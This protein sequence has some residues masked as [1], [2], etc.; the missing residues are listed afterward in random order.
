MIAL[1]QQPGEL[2][3]VRNPIVYRF[4]STD[5]VGEPYQATGFV[6]RILF[7]PF[8][9]LNTG[10][11]L[12]LNWSDGES[13]YSYTFTGHPAPTSENQLL[14]KPHLLDAQ[15]YAQNWATAFESHPV[16]SAFFTITYYTFG[17]SAGIILEDKSKNPDFTLSFDFSDASEF[18]AGNFL[19]SAYV[20]TTLPDNYKVKID[21]YFQSEFVDGTYHHVTRLEETPDAD[22]YSEIDLED[23]LQA[24]LIN[25]FQNPDLPVINSSNLYIANNLRRYYIRF[26]EFYGTPVQEQ[27]W[28]FGSTKKVINGGI[29]QA[30]FAGFDFFGQL[31][32]TNSFL[33]WYPDK[34]TV[35]E[36]QPEY[37]SWFNYTGT[38]KEICLRFTTYDE[39]NTPT[40]SIL[41][42]DA[43][44]SVESLQTAIIPVGFSQLGL[45]DSSIKKYTIQVVTRIPPDT[46]V[47]REDLSQI[48]TFYLDCNFRSCIEYII[49]FDG[50]GLPQSLRLTGL[51]KKQLS[52]NRKISGSILQSSYGNLDKEEFQFDFDWSNI[53]TFRTGYLSKTEVDA[54]QQILIYNQAYQLKD[55]Q[56]FPLLITDKKYDITEHFQFLHSLQ[57]RAI[58]ALKPKNYSNDVIPIEECCPGTALC[59]GNQ[60]ISFSNNQIITFG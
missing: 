25:S 59:V 22:G 20:S 17:S 8:A 2:S 13:D 36:F 37:L 5:I 42:N 55:D 9:S 47:V 52:V 51:T 11:N 7:S 26:A 15:Q 53:I 24:E 54:L 33:S 16:I 14:S 39:S 49:Y 4:R 50:F 41:Y 3:F 46:V 10:E 31:S 30:R 35:D 32:E 12:I 58:R 60:I 38:R 40:E 45:S 57:F 27:N 19:I 43:F 6:G 56:Y 34:K 21:V 48:R 28:T 1:N 23:I 44:L 18:V 29:D